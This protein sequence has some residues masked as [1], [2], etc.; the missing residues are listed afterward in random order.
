MEYDLKLEGQ[1]ELTKAMEKVPEQAE[2]EINKVLH[3][4]GSK[5]VMENI[6]K[7][8]PISKGGGKHA[9]TSNPLKTDTINLGFSTYAKGGA[10]NTRGSFGYLVFPDEGRGP[11]NPVA[12]NFFEKGVQASEPNILEMLLEALERASEL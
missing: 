8:M 2:K 3:G 12:Q 4:D 5:L 6:I 7:F 10:A 1:E 11:R 9:K